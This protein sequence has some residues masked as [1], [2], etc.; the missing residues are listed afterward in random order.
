M[1][2]YVN[3]RVAVLFGL[4]MIVG[5]QQQ[6]PVPPPTPAPPAG[7]TQVMTV[8]PDMNI[9]Q[10]TSAGDT[11]E[12]RSSIPGSPTFY[13]HFIG[14]GPCGTTKIVASVNGVASCKVVAPAN[15]GPI[16]YKYYIDNKKLSEEPLSGPHSC[17]GCSLQ[18]GASTA[19][20]PGSG[21]ASSN[22]TTAS[23]SGASNAMSSTA[24]TDGAI[25]IDC[26]SGKISVEGP[27]KPGNYIYWQANS[28][29]AG[30]SVTFPAT[31]TKP[32]C[33]GGI[34]TFN[35]SNSVC[36]LSNPPVKSTFSITTTDCPT[37]A[38]FPV[39]AAK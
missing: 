38:T 32:L 25:Y 21:A 33:Q 29:A 23:P 2:E 27:S 4:A 5:C 14:S 12:W 34:T 9:L 37:P 15:P 13:V 24:T 30:W 28:D 31:G 19:G 16:Y 8:T 7:N 17:G 20:Q 10:V 36:T 18:Q 35:A 3:F 6:A 1:R 26:N 11:L 39:P 22:S